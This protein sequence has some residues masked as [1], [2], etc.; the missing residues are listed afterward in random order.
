MKKLKMSMK[1]IEGI[2]S[3]DE[4]KKILG[5]SAGNTFCWCGPNA[6]CPVSGLPGK[7]CTE[8]CR[9]FENGC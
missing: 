4:L 5:G 9:G 7:T 1:N 6:D 2:L 8:V 3:R